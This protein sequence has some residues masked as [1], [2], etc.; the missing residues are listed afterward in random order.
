MVCKIYTFGCFWKYISRFISKRLIFFCFLYSFCSYAHPSANSAVF[1]KYQKD[2][3]LAEIQIPVNELSLAMNLNLDSNKTYSIKGKEKLIEKYIYA[4]IAANGASKI[5]WKIKIINLKLNAIQKKEGNF[6][7]D[8]VV[9]LLLIP[10][11]IKELENFK[12]N[13]DVVLDQ[14]ATHTVFVNV[15]YNEIG[16]DKIPKTQEIGIIRRDIVYDKIN[17]LEISNSQT[18]SAKGM[19]AMFFLGIKHIASGFDHLLFLF[20]LLLPVPLKVLNGRWEGIKSIKDSS[21]LIFKIVTAF[22]IGHSITLLFGAL[23]WLSFNTQYVEVLIGIS[24]LISGIHAL[25]PIFYRKENWVA[26][27]FGLIHG[28]AFASSLEILHLDFSQKMRSIFSFNLGIECM[29]LSLVLFSLPFLITMLK[30]KYYTEFKNIGAGCAIIAAIVW[31]IERS[32]GKANFIS[33]FLKQ[34]IG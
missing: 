26:S 14:V 11:D 1:L 16:Q 30:T 7:Q 32:S 3:I 25:R 12:L 2:Q 8:V 33:D 9:K 17:S 23:G 13:Y 18:K 27:G 29:Q 6:F 31:I 21:L 20:V 10:P 28:L 34:I 4:H 19:K 22:T 5:A 15:L 24:I